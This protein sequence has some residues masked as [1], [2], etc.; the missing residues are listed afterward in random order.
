MPN[1]HSTN[2]G[3]EKKEFV[4]RERQHERK[5]SNDFNTAVRPELCRRMNGFFSN[6]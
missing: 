3:A 2:Q 6:G 4:L 1:E 5:F